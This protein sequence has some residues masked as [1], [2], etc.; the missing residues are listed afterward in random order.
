M[1]VVD[2]SSTVL[3]GVGIATATALAMPWSSVD[4]QSTDRWLVIRNGVQ[5]L[6]IANNH[7]GWTVIITA[8]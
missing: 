3:T 6:Y 1:Y 2:S 5:P 8:N 7:G 4:L